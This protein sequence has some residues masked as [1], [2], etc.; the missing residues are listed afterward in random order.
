MEIS[1]PRVANGLP[2]SYFVL[3]QPGKIA[4]EHGN[5]FFLIFFALLYT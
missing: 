2:N 5:A 1:L 4:P 3:V